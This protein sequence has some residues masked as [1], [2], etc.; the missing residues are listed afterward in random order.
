MIK[1]VN[2]LYFEGKCLANDFKDAP[3]IDSF[4]SY[5]QKLKENHAMLYNMPIE[6][7]LIFFNEVSKRLSIEMVHFKKNSLKMESIF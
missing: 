7:I 5:Y 2:L 3:I 6:D 4:D 1:G